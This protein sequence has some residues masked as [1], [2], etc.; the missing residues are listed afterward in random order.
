MDD[1]SPEHFDRMLYTSEGITERVR[2]DLT[3]PD[4]QPG[5]DISGFTMRNHYLEMSK[6]AYTVDGEATPWVQVPHS[7]AWYGADRCAPDEEGNLVAGPPQRM[8]GHPDNPAGPGQL[9]VDAA[10][11][12][13]EQ[14]PDFPLADYDIE[15]QF[16]RDGDGNFFE[17]DGY[18]DH[19]VLV[20]AGEDKSGGGGAEGVYAIWAHSSTV[21][22]GAAHR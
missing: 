2:P 14:H 16:D 22:N 20:H 3:G 10:N 19:V 4:G 21:V 9:A 5:I 8:V 13:I 12:L 1:F 17:P 7:E 18:V 11:A 15:D 6:G